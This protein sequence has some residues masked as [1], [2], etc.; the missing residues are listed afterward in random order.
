MSDLPPGVPGAGM[1]FSVP[2]SGVG[3]RICGSTLLGGQS[4]PSV[5]PSRSLGVLS[6]CPVV[7]DGAGSRPFGPGVSRRSPG[8]QAFG[9]GCEVCGGDCAEAASALTVTHNNE[10]N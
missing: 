7:S 5:R 4:T 8:A 1:T 9:S 6:A 10:A 3:A 2:A